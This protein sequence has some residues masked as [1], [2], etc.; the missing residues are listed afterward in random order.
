MESNLERVSERIAGAIMQFR[1]NCAVYNRDEFR[2]EDLR[3]F[4]FRSCCGHMAPGS[5]DRVLRS[6]RS[7][8]KLDYVVVNRRQSIYRWRVTER[9]GRDAGV[10]M[11]VSLANAKQKSFL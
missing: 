10:P 9:L 8:K 5:A 11:A 4:V 2:A 6:L 1:Q 3:M 7:Q